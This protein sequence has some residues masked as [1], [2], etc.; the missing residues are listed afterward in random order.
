[1]NL[2]KLRGLGVFI[3]HPFLSRQ[4]NTLKGSVWIF[5]VSL[6]PLTLIYLLTN[7]MMGGIYE[8]SIETFYYH[9][10]ILSKPA[11]SFS[12]DALDPEGL[13]PLAG[14][15]EE[16]QGVALLSFE[17][18]QEPLLLRGLEPS[19]LAHES[20]WQ[21]LT[22]E[23]GK[24]LSTPMVLKEGEIALGKSLAQSLGVREGET[25]NLITQ[26]TIAGRQVPRI[27]TLNVKTIFSTGYTELDKIWAL[28]SLWEEEALFDPASRSLWGV[29]FQ[30]TPLDQIPALTASLNMREQAFSWASWQDL[31]RNQIENFQS[32]K[33]LFGVLFSLMVVVAS[34]N[35][36]S[37][38][39]IYI[40]EQKKS[41]AILKALGLTPSSLSLS[42]ALIGSLVGFLGALL[43]LSFSLILS[44]SLNPLLKGVFRLTETLW[45]GVY[46]ILGIEVAGSLSQLQ[47]S[48]YLSEIPISLPFSFLAII[49][50]ASLVLTLLS[51][52]LSIKKLKEIKPIELLS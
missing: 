13:P 47:E 25:V 4:K 39:I 10:Q 51:S 41:L 44:I 2:K 1:M 34:F 38:L 42:F 28:V 15:W 37:A 17:E 27:T 8:R 11:F 50:G 30:D 36:S 48:Y 49:L 24:G 19:F 31:N 7:G 22:D 43:G 16:K 12:L 6:L 29:K 23:K 3:S 9:A 14:V 20:F 52:L 32:L 26:R 45:Q 18:R 5:A 21:Y 33:R 35:V 40:W 46:A